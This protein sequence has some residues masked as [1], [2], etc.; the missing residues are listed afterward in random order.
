MSSTLNF[1]FFLQKTFSGKVKKD[2][3]CLPL[4]WRKL[5]RPTKTKEK[6]LKKKERKNSPFYKKTKTKNGKKLPNRPQETFWKFKRKV[7]SS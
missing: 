4:L 7:M 3:P 6:Y 1:F 2:I 5:N